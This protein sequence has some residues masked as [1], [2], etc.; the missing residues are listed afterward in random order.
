[1]DAGGLVGIG[2]EGLMMGEGVDGAED[3]F[4]AFAFCD[5]AAGAGGLGDIDEVGAIVHGE[6]QDGSAG[7][8]LGD[9]TGGGEAVH[10][11]HGDVEDDD[12][13]VQSLRLLNGFAA[14]GGFSADLDTGT[15]AEDCAH[16]YAH[17]FVIVRN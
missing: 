10:H 7:G 6:E 1:M 8:D 5:V 13:R 11:G 15:G 16:A 12:V 3:Y 14:I 2:E 9:F 17:S 4:A